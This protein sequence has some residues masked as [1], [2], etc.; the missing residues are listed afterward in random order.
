MRDMIFRFSFVAC[1]LGFFGACSTHQAN[2]KSLHD[3]YLWLEDV[4]SKRSASWVADQNKVT[5]DLLQGDSRFAGFKKQAAEILQDKDRI[6]RVAIRGPYVYSFWQDKEHVH[7][8]WR[9][10]LIESYESEGEPEWEIL[11]DFDALAAAD[12]E[13]WVYKGSKCLPPTYERCL[14]SLSR[15]GKDAVVV[16]EFDLNQKSFVPDGFHLAEA[17]SIITWIDRDRVAVGTD[18]GPGSLV[19]SGY[20]RLIKVWKRGQALDQAPL[21]MEGQKTDVYLWMGRVYRPEGSVTL[22]VRRVSF[23]KAEYWIF[24][25]NFKKTR[26]EVPLDADYQGV[27]HG[28]LLFLLQSPMGNMPEGAL[29]SVAIDSESQDRVKVLLEPGP[30][31]AV[32]DLGISRDFVFVNTLKNVKGD[33][34]RFSL[35][36]DGQWQRAQVDIPG[37]SSVS[38]MSQATASNKI[39]IVTE[40]F[41]V[42]KTVY[43]LEPSQNGPGTSRRIK[44]QKEI[45][46]SSGM[47][48]E[49]FFAESK[50]GTKIPYFVI[51]PR[52]IK[53]DGANPTLLYGYGGFRVSMTPRYLKIA[54]KLWLQHGGVYVLSNIRGGGEFGPSWHKAA[55][56]GNRQKA[57][58][59][60]IAVTEDLF[61]RGI[62]SS[63]RLGIEGGSNGG[64]LVGAAFTQRPDLYKAV[65]C[66]VPLLDMIRY[67]SLLAGASWMEEY[68]DPR[69]DDMRET[70]LKYSPY[71]NLKKERDYPEVFF[72]TSSK[73]DR[74]HPAHARKM[75]AR[76][77]AMGKN[78]L[79]FEHQD[80]GH[81]VRANL[82]QKARLQALQYVYL[83]QKLLN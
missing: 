57:F 74:V 82:Q 35:D 1:W 60:F 76:M 18:Y 46:D 59:D 38:I 71:H 72:I 67:S 61:A 13:N 63:D 51:R 79:F 52:D 27:F 12:T 41:L 42:P 17:K 80:G 26:V 23:F 70:I 28:R 77:K 62:T 2:P 8:L 64:L 21:V 15:G 10:A 16:R 45:F 30:N 56:R 24:D 39:Y 34:L 47:V 14:V 22:G 40:S 50:D 75:T 58:D 31:S 55:L 6:P 20:P 25:E 49:Q 78:A 29:V 73:D 44:R 32:E 9:R 53:Y 3:P 83:H 7:G 5:L 43:A 36:Q 68:G 65:L 4:E 69:Q 54:G 66:E 48:T 37:H 33:L 11:L 81:S 19:D